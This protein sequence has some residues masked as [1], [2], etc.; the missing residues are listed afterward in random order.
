LDC[1]VYPEIEYKE[2]YEKLADQGRLPL[3]GSIELTFRCNLNCVHCYVNL[4]AGDAAARQKELPGQEWCRIIDEIVDA[5]CLW[6]LV[7]G[8]EPLLHPDFLDIYNYAKKS[9]LL[10]T[11]FTNGT[12]LTPAIADHWVEWPPHGVEISIYGSSKETYEAVTRVSGSFDRC[13]HGI[14]LLLERH[15]R[16]ELK[17]VV[18][19]TNHH[20][21]REMQIWSAGLGVDFRFD[22]VLNPR[23]DGS[24]EP[25][26]LRLSPE[27]V[28]SL[29]RGDGRRLKDFAKLLEKFPGPPSE[30]ESLYYCGAGID[31]FHVDAYGNLSICM[32]AREPHFS[33]LQGSFHEGWQGFLAAVRQQ[34]RTKESPCASCQL[35]SLCGLC[36][37]WAQIEAGDQEG[38]VDY[39][40][41]IA[42][43][44]AEAFSQISAPDQPDKGDP[45]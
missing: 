23:I 20:E 32:M 18:L 7:T 9:G 21:L 34:K 36:P 44:R 29:D 22:P 43:L 38:Q 10:I 14:E 31:T 25:C 40:C 15:I 11:I 4:P 1:P 35:I 27:A 5:G 45:L 17:T 24:L 30:P 8:G 12:L 6:L 37:G 19:T 41:R 39:L 42:H 13:R 33:L 3:V 16:L 2:F 28:V 26:R